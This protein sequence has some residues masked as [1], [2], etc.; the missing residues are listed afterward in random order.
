MHPE[1]TSETPAQCPICGMA[2]V[3]IAHI[4]AGPFDSRAGA[5]SVDH[6]GA[7]AASADRESSRRRYELVDVA[8]RRVISEVLVAPAWLDADGVVT[9]TVYDEEIG[10]LGPGARATFVTT[11][12]PGGGLAV[13]ATGEQPERWD[14]QTSR[15]R[16]RMDGV[17]G[18]VVPDIGAGRLRPGDV[19]WVTVPDDAREL[20]VVPS[21]A[22]LESPDGAYVLTPATSARSTEVDTL[23]RR[24]LRV[25]RIANGL[26]VVAS[27][28][29][30]GERVIV[31]NAFFLD[32]ERRLHGADPAAEAR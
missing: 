22:V 31:G 10:R 23:E 25:G 12:A 17:A 27:G 6:A 18:G 16:L 30:A 5:G 32:A 7:R 9:A 29:A 1:V 28:L 20:V 8:R 13:V 26:A 14:T 11:G 3:P 15:V 19:G 21:T 4:E 24:A 2:L